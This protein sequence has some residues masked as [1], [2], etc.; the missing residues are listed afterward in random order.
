[1]SKAQRSCNVGPVPEYDAAQLT[2]AFIG[3][4]DHEASDD[5]LFE[6]GAYATKAKSSGLSLVWLAKL[7]YMI[8]VLLAVGPAARL[9]NTDIKKRF[10]DALATRPRRVI[11]PKIPKTELSEL[12]SRQV[13]KSLG[14]FGKENPLRILLIEN[15]VKLT[16]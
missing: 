4:I 14:K 7:S 1:M 15:V 10:L 8:I 16:S 5:K 12:V 13:V 3:Y 9:H 6:F 2:D 11:F